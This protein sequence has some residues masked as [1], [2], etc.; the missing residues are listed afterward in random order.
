VARAMMLRPIRDI[1]HQVYPVVILLFSVIF[2]LYAS[3]ITEMMLRTGARTIFERKVA[4]K[5]YQ[6]ASGK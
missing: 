5:K 4:G 1:C 2:A 3:R 6:T